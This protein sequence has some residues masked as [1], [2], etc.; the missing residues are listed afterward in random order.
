MLGLGSWDTAL[1]FW[2]CIISAIGCVAY[3]FINWNNTGTPDT[4]SIDDV[5]PDGSCDDDR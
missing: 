2:L 1:A 5:L 4:I 3:G